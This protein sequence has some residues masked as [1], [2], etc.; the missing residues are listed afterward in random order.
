[1]REWKDGEEERAGSDVYGK[2]R[3]IEQERDGLERTLGREGAMGRRKRN[4][5]KR[6]EWGGRVEEWQ[7]LERSRNKG[8]GRKEGV[9][10]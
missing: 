2:R 8:V 7:S 6:E 4:G 10:H 5:V 3:R 1:M 9:S